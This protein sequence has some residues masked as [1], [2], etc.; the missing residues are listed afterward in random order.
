MVRPAE[1]S[2]CIGILV[3][4]ASILI[5]SLN[6]NFDLADS[7]QTFAV[8]VKSVSAGAQAVL[9]HRREDG[10]I[11]ATGIVAAEW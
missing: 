6:G 1:H 8:N 11:A 3:N 4:N 10:Y 5:R 7:E 2:G 9:P